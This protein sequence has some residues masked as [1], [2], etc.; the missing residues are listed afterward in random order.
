MEL[1]F[2]VINKLL[3]TM[4]IIVTLTTITNVY[5]QN[6]T[7]YCDMYMSNCLNSPNVTYA[8][9]NDCLTSCSFFPL[10]N[11]N[12]ASGN[13]Y[14][15]RYNALLLL[16]TSACPIAYSVSNGICGGMCDIYCSG[17]ST[18]CPSVFSSVASCKTSCLQYQTL[19]GSLGDTAGNTV[20][21]RY[22]A[23]I[24]A[25]ESGNTTFYCPQASPIGGGTCVSNCSWYCSLWN[26]YCTTAATQFYSRLSCMDECVNFYPSLTINSSNANL[27]PLGDTVQC[28]AYLILSEKSASANFS[29]CQDA[30]PF[31]GQS[32]CGTACDNYCDHM[33]KSCHSVFNGSRPSCLTACAKYS[34][35]TGT[36]FDTTDTTDSFNCRY[37][38]VVLAF[39]NNQT[40]TYC[41]HAAPDGGGICGTMVQSK[42]N[43]DLFKSSFHQFSI[44][45]LVLFAVSFVIGE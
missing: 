21:C 13:S 19:G 44:T 29:N 5:G 7:D 42:A 11:P 12:D 2:R 41:P 4:F 17:M 35:L 8:D 36:L 3:F 32:K 22:S 45:L 23:V 9:M 24:N 18:T 25:N 28:R 20:F 39:V 37:T 43:P 38:Q 27:P 15:C 40:S 10:G 14:Y 30:I 33:D 6:C 1:R 34:T 16:N 31:S 26:N